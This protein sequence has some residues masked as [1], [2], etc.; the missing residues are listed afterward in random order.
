MLSSALQ[1]GGA[2]AITIGAALV[3]LP[4]GLVV[5]GAFLIVIGLGLGR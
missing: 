4:A 5:G 2:L 3:F 1:I